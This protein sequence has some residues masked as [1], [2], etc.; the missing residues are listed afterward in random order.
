M[1]NHSYLVTAFFAT[2]LTSPVLADHGPGTSGSGVSTQSAETLKPRQWSANLQ[3][4]WTEFDP[5]GESALIGKDHFDLIDRSFFTTLSI[6]FGITENFQIS[7]S[8]GYYAASGTRNIVHDHGAEGEG[9]EHAE[10]DHD[11]G[12]EH[13]EEHEHAETGHEHGEEHEHGDSHSHGSTK[14]KLASFDP[15]GFSDL[16]LNAK[17]RLYRGPAGQFAVYAGVKFPVGESRVI[18]SEGERVEPAST[19]GSGAWDGMVGGAYTITLSPAL[20]LDASAQYIFRGEKFNHRLGNRFDAGVALG[21]TVRGDAKQYPR[22]TL[23]GE[24][25]LRVIAKGEEEGQ[26]DE[27]TGGTTLFLSPG[28]RVA[29]SEHAAFTVAAQFPVVQD[30]N[31]DQVETSFRVSTSFNVAF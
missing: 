9:D 28:V 10:E 13:G 18:D 6:S 1:K 17:Y 20:A 7:L 31:G 4:D 26:R 25:L 21:W 11:A 8:S 5:P 23:I 27:N 30:L 16:W 14:P 22:V 24:G 2:L 19:P 29:F 3:A 12:H 15:D